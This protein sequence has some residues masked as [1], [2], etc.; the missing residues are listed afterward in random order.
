MNNQSQ[1]CKNIQEKNI[2][3]G[4]GLPVQRPKGEIGLRVE[5]VRSPCGR[6]GVSRE[7]QERGSGKRVAARA[8]PLAGQSS[9]FILSS[10]GSL[11]RLQQQ[12]P[13]G[14]CQH[15]HSSG[16]CLEGRF[17]PGEQAGVEAGMKNTAPSC[18]DSTCAVSLCSLHFLTTALRGSS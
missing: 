17:G 8:G 1:P 5:V 4:R 14:A 6:R 3:G 15:D 11:Q 10:M 7:P 18:S 9:D 2:L 16:C 12:S 13:L